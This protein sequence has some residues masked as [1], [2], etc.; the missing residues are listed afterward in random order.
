MPVARSTGHAGKALLV[1]AVGVVIALGVAF[2]AST[3]ETDEGAARL[4]FGEP[5]FTA[6]N[7]DRLA[8][9]IDRD[10][11]AFFPALTGD[12][13]IYLQHEG[14]DPEEGWLAFAAFVPEDP[15]CLVVWSPEDEVFV[16][17]CDESVTFPADGEGLRQYETRVRDGVVRIDIQGITTTTTT[18]PAATSSTTTTT[19]PELPDP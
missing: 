9:A 6:G 16:S 7:A 15:S 18:E 12:R 4:T 19:L 2:W 10:G 1:A 8:A 14:D 5:I 3:W 11:P 13:P 17:Q